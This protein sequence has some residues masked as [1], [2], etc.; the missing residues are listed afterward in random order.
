VTSAAV[1][2]RPSGMRVLALSMKPSFCAGVRPPLS[3][4]GVMMGPGL[5]VLTRMPRGVSSL[6]IVRPEDPLRDDG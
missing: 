3:R 5:I 6:A 4:I 1:P 2:V